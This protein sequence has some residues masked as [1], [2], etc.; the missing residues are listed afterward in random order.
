MAQ[1]K[2]ELAVGILFF[3]GI[4]VLTYFTVVMKDEFMSPRDSFI[5]VA[6]FPSVNGLKKDERVKMLGVDVGSITSIA[7]NGH[8]VR[9]TFKISEDVPFYEN[10]ALQIRSESIMSGKYLSIDPGTQMTDKRENKLIDRKKPLVGEVP[11][12]VMSLV[13]DVLKENRSDIRSSVENLRTVS[14]NLSAVTGKINRGEGTIGKLVNE[15]QT[16]PVKDLVNEVRDTVE[17]AREQAP[18]TSFIRAIMTVL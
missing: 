3:V 16:Q 5:I 4:A 11:S 10:Y 6:D 12:D 8:G 14:E 7:F 15:D 2:N 18:V 9:V 1:L 17:D 13:E